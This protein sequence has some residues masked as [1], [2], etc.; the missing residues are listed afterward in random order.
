MAFRAHTVFLGRAPNGGLRITKTLEC[1]D[2]GRESQP[3]DY[4]AYIVG[5]DGPS[6]VRDLVTWLRDNFPEHFEQTAQPEPIEQR[7]AVLEK[8]VSDI[9]G[10]LHSSA[11]ALGRPYDRLVR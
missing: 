9:T 7:V 5:G 6:E 10:A 8:T 2:K 4:I 3:G 11:A 1:A